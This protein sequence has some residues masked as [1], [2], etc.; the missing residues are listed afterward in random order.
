TIANAEAQQRFGSWWVTVAD[1]DPNVYVAGTFSSS[2]D[3]LRHM[4]SREGCFW[5][6][7]SKTRCNTDGTQGMLASGDAGTLFLDLKCFGAQDDGQTYDMAFSDYN[8]IDRLIRSGKVIGFAM[9]LKDGA[10]KVS[11][12]TTTGAVEAIVEAS[13]RAGAGQNQRVPASR[14]D[15]RL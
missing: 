7:T 6:F 14:R 4:C 1:F 12:F 11:R 9:A 2:G 13:R 3:M 15:E 8:A 10:F 5:T